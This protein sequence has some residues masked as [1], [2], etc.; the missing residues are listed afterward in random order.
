MFPHVFIDCSQSNRTALLLSDT[1]TVVVQ[2]LVNNLQSVGLTVNYISGGISTY[3]GSP[4]AANYDSVILITG[5]DYA[6]DMPSSGQES[7]RN[8]QQNSGT[9]I[10]MTEWAAYQVLSGRWSVLSSLLLATRITGVTA[11][12][13]FDLVSINHPIWNGLAA[14][15]N[16]SVTLGYS[17]LST[18]IN[19]SL[20]IAS[21]MQCGGPAVIVRPS[22][23]SNGRI[24]QIAHGGHYS[25][26][27][28]NF[29]WQN[30]ANL[31]TMM[32]N[33]VK[34]AAKMI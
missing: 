5:N 30:D 11:S 9:G 34:W 1:S 8:A 32:N 10:V 28:A 29:N 2:T 27:G 14:S 20:T 24:V 26:G 16:T 17:V 19:G 7:I 3:S 25:S 21:C 4:N 13:S 23:A 6:T 22:V 33:A 12:M 18:P 15:F 31:V